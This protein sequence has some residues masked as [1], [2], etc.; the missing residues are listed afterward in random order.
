MIKFLDNLILRTRQIRPIWEILK[1]KRGGPEDPPADP[2][3][4]DP[5]PTDPPPTDPPE[6]NAFFD[7]LSEENRAVNVNNVATLSKFKS[8]D[9]LAKSYVNLE[10]KISQKGVIVPKADASPEEKES[11]LNAIGR[12]EAPE[13]YKIDT[14]DG[15]HDSITVTPES[16]AAFQ[17]E[18]H[19]MGFTN[20]QANQL[21]SWY[22]KTVSASAKEYSDAQDKAVNDAETALRAEWK[23][24][25]DSNKDLVAKMMLNAGGQEAIDAMGGTDGIGN[26]PHILKALATVAGQLSEDQIGNLKPVHHGGTGNE[27]Q[28][29]AVTKINEY[30]AQLNSDPKSAIADENH[31]HHKEAV[32]DRT[33]LYKI[34]YPG[35]G[36]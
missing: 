16:Q 8:A 10:G 25:Y 19:K 7:G 23:E 20:E 11:Y 36:E 13:G 2:P 29:D 34:A 12:P 28:Q 4:N 26:N 18:A 22:L 27:S 15:L 24:N 9:E 30:N 32:S 6:G 31:P 5:P 33:R 35:G 14:I 17:V 3:P 1:C 21:N